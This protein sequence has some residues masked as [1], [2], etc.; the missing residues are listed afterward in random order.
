MKLTRR[1]WLVYICWAGGMT[2]QQT[3][4]SLGVS[5]WTVNEHR[6]RIRDKT[7]S[8]RPHMMEAPDHD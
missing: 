8:K 1:Q 6:D 3:A 5:Y 7:Q 4:D 2:V